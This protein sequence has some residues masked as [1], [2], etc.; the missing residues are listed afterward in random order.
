[1]L[2]PEIKKATALPPAKVRL[3]YV[4]GQV[5]TF[6]ME[7]LLDKGIFRELRDPAMFASVHAVLDTVEWANG[8]DVE[9][10]WLY[11]DSVPEE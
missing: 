1:M 10:E 9:P 3:E 8:A 11:E 5:R 2:P 6:D 7:P 4:D